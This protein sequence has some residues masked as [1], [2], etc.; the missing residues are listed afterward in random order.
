MKNRATSTRK[1][2]NFAIS[3]YGRLGL[4]LIATILLVKVSVSGDWSRYKPF[5]L[6]QIADF[7][8]AAIA[9][10][11]HGPGATVWREA[12]KI[13]IRIDQYPEPSVAA[14]YL[15]SLKLFGLSMGKPDL[16][17]LFKQGYSL[18]RT[19]GGLR[20]RLVFQ[21]SL[22]PCLKKEAGLGDEVMFYVTCGCYNEWK[23]ELL[24][25]VNEFEV[26]ESQR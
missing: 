1:P 25:L 9:E 7:V 16:A 26:P 12:Y 22:I 24:L 23:K 15:G 21:D 17:E 10:P 6:E 14:D 11:D 3:E 4:T 19:V 13:P 5:T 20:I 18:I 2:A 8:K